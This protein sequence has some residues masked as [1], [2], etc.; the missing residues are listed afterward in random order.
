M[1]YAQNEKQFVEITKTD[2]KL[3]KLKLFLFF[4]NIISH[5]L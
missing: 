5:M 2:H 3:S 1:G 4:E